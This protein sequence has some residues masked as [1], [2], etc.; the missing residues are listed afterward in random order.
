MVRLADCNRAVAKSPEHPLTLVSI[1]RLEVAR[2]FEPRC[3]PQ[4]PAEVGHQ[5]QLRV[6]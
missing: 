3:A 2:V 6:E 5:W 1:G 4:S